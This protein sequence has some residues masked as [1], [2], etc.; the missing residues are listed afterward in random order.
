MFLTCQV[1][2]QQIQIIDLDFSSPSIK[3]LT[4]KQSVWTDEREKRRRRGLTSRSAGNIQ[5]WIHTCCQSCWWGNVNEQ[6]LTSSLTFLSFYS[7]LLFLLSARQKK[8]HKIKQLCDGSGGPG[9]RELR[10]FWNW[11]RLIIHTVCVE[12]LSERRVL[13]FPSRRH[14]PSLHGGQ[15]NLNGSSLPAAANQSAGWLLRTLLPS[16]PS[17]PW[18]RQQPLNPLIG[19]RTRKILHDAIDL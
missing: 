5:T 8:P 15:K 10:S 6:P 18:W 17:A 14:A 12:Y 2:S 9:R 4:K 1:Q 13:F 11:S 3:Q 16:P 19:K 7:L